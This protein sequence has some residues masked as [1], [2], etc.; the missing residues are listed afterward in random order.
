VAQ[1]AIQSAQ[2]NLMERIEEH[3]TGGDFLACAEGDDTPFSHRGL[4]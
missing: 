3:D 1:E 4:S 2:E